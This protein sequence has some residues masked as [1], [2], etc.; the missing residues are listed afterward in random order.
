LNAEA[1]SSAD[2]FEALIEST[3]VITH[4][5]GLTFKVGGTSGTPRIELA[6]AHCHLEVPTHSIDDVISIETNFHALPSNISDTDELVIT[7]VGA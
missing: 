7:Y 1:D 2:L 6:M 3:D 4:D 5:F